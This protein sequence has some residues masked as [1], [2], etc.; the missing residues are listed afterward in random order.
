MTRRQV[1]LSGLLA[2]TIPLGSA[3]SGEM[4]PTPPHKKDADVDLVSAGKARGGVYDPITRTPIA[5]ARVSFRTGRA[6]PEEGR[7]TSV[8]DAAGYFE[9]EVELGRTQKKTDALLLLGGIA[10]GGVL[11]GTFSESIRVDV[12]QLTARVTAPGYKPFEGIVRCHRVHAM[13]FDVHLEPILL[14]PESAPGASVCADHWSIA[15]IVDFRL[16]PSIVLPEETITATLVFASPPPGKDVK[17]KDHEFKAWFDLPDDKIQ[18]MKER[19]DNGDGTTTFRTTFK[20]PKLPKRYTSRVWSCTPAISAPF[21][22]SGTQDALLSIVLTEEAKPSAKAR[23]AAFKSM[24]AG[25]LAV[26]ADAFLAVAKA[27]T[28]IA[29]DWTHAGRL[30]AQLGRKDDAVDAFRNA[31]QSDRNTFSA[32]RLMKALDAIGKAEDA[33]QEGMRHLAEVRS[34]AKESDLPK[35]FH[36]DFLTTLGT[37][38]VHAGQAAAARETQE[39]YA[40]HWTEAKVDRSLEIMVRL[41]EAD[42]RLKTAPNDPAALAERAAVLRDQERWPEA[43]AAVDAALAVGPRLPVL[44]RDRVFARLHLPDQTISVGE[45]ETA[46]LAAEPLTL[47]E[48]GGKTKPVKDFT[49]HHILGVLRTAY[50][51]AE[52]DAVADPTDLFDKAHEAFDEALRN[53]RLAPPRRPWNATSYFVYSSGF[54]SGAAFGDFDLRQSLLDLREDPRDGLA[55]TEMAGAL[56]SLGLWHLAGTV[57]DEAARV[58]RG[59]V[60][61]RFLQA[62]TAVAQGRPTEGEAGLRAVIDAAPFHPFA[63]L[64]LATLLEKRDPAEAGRLRE[65][66]QKR[67]TGNPKA[68]APVESPP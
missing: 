38:Q 12:D 49:A 33:A 5:G 52:R 35:W 67:F 63:R 66:H 60:E 16:E 68:A 13:H 1:I 32:E 46:I 55:L 50:A 64:R 31:Y 42:L 45:I 23:E 26:A 34:K 8:T 20:A 3:W 14:M 65:E 39:L 61:P 10:A 15:R 4:F 53:G 30:F 47:H 41:A 48:D 62:M 58:S 19:T 17:G 40:R 25:D 59:A 29:Y 36:A 6:F 28:G 21:I 44:I 22:Y 56:T 2:S 43:L 7:G 11:P 54:R 18:E 27:P 51:L 37:A 24:V 57:A 9:A